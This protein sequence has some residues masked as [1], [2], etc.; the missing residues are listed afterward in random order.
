MKLFDAAARDQIIDGDTLAL[1]IDCQNA[2]SQYVDLGPIDAVVQRVNLAIGI[3][4]VNIVVI[5]ERDVTNAGARAG[6]SGPGSDAANSDDAEPGALQRVECFYTEN[7][8]EA[9]ES[10]QVLGAWHL[11]RFLV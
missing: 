11:I 5:D 3:A 2:F 10:L 1:G 7:P 6:L 9:F 8:T 4:D